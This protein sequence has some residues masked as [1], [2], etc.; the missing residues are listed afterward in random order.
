MTEAGRRA[1]GSPCL[2]IGAGK[3]AAIDRWPDLVGRRE[4]GHR[5]GDIEAKRVSARP[6]AVEPDF[7]LA[8]PQREMTALLGGA[9]FAA[10]L[11]VAGICVAM[12]MAVRST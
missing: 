12:V 7:M 9:I 10:A 8:T 2:H 6:K 3:P 11:R 5:S 4:V 1:G